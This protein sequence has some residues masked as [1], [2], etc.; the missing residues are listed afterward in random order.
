[1]A[2]SRKG[3]KEEVKGFTEF[4]K[5]VYRCIMKIP[6]GQVRSYKWVAQRIAKPRA[7]R[8][9]GTALKKNPFPVTIP[10]HR[11]VK[12]CG[13][14][15]NYSSGKSRKRKLINLEKKIKDMIE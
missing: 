14:I 10:C 11:V 1:M 15:G 5:S 7:F 9:V 3:A 12:N 8:A 2:K 4:E 13:D 6:L